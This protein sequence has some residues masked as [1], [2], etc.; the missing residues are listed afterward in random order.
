LTGEERLR[1]FVH[2]AV[3]SDLDALESE[4]QVLRRQVAVLER[5]AGLPSAPLGQSERRVKVLELHRAGASANNIAQT[6]NCAR[7]TVQLDL[8]AMGLR[9]TAVVVGLD[10]RFRAARPN[11]RP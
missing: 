5:M 9:S 7:R 11:D 6:L 2:T 10:G 3:A 4:L 8:E 1:E